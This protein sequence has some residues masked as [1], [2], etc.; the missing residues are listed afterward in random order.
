MN[1]LAAI[2]CLVVLSASQFCDETIPLT[3]ICEFPMTPLHTTTVSP[4]Q[5]GIAIRCTS[6]T[7]EFGLRQIQHPAFNFFKLVTDS[8]DVAELPYFAVNNEWVTY[9]LSFT[10]HQVGDYLSD[11]VMTGRSDLTT[12][13]YEKTVRGLTSDGLCV[14]VN[15]DQA[16]IP[17]IGPLGHVF[18]QL[19][20]QSGT[21]TSGE[22]TYGFYSAHGMPVDQGRLNNDTGRVWDARVCFPVSEASIIEAELFITQSIFFPPAYHVN[23]FCNQWAFDV[24]KS[25]GIPDLAFTFI[26]EDTK[27]PTRFLNLLTE[28][29]NGGRLGGGFIEINSVDQQQ[30][31]TPKQLAWPISITPEIFVPILKNPQGVADFFGSPLHEITLPNVS[32]SPSAEVRVTLTGSSVA[33]IHWGDFPIAD[34]NALNFEFPNYAPGVPP[35]P[36][37]T[38]THRYDHAGTYPATLAVTRNGHIYI[39][40]WYFNVLGSGLTESTDTKG[41]SDITVVVPNDPVVLVPNKGFVEPV[42]PIPQGIFSDGFESGNTSGWSTT[43]EN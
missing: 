35:H 23:H 9:V 17:I 22:L 11:V 2:A 41:T 40:R 27:Y 29:G 14:Y 3:G 42:V 18:V 37:W 10:P 5:F 6:T 16:D 4:S 7:C 31:L 8:G 28:R 1:T 25:A 30:E 38:F 13:C 24:A 34:L 32:T 15:D 33:S 20:P 12:R 19:L 21:Q 26:R 39:Y 43:I 36:F